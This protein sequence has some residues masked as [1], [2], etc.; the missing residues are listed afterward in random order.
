MSTKSKQ[1]HLVILSA[2]VKVNNDAANVSNFDD[3]SRPGQEI[4]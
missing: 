1:K 2:R 4:R 3:S